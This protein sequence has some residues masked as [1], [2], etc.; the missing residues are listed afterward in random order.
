MIR[1]IRWTALE[2]SRRKRKNWTAFLRVKW[3]IS[4]PISKS[5]RTRRSETRLPIRSVQRRRHFQDSR[6]SSRWS[7]PA[8]ILSSLTNT[9]VCVTPWKSYGSTTRRSFTS[10]RRPQR[11]AS[12]SDADF[13]ACFTWKSFRSASSVSFSSRSSRP[14]RACDIALRTRMERSRKSTTRRSFLMRNSSPKWKSLL[15]QP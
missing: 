9:R 3:V 1:F 6:K 11:W 2:R 10:R 4:L 15:S 5:L 7:S 8:C 14:R 12:V 13:L